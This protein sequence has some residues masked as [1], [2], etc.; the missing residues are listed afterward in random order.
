VKEVPPLLHKRSVWKCN[1][2]FWGFSSLISLNIIHLCCSR[3]PKGRVLSLSLRVRMS[4]S[5]VSD[6]QMSDIQMSDIQMSDIQ[7]SDIWMSDI[8]IS[9]LRMSD[10]RMSNIRVSNIRVSNIRMSDIRMSDIR[11]LG[12]T[13]IVLDILV[14][15]LWSLPLSYF[16][17]IFLHVL[18]QRKNSHSSS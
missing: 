12:Y 8:R 2:D 1:G 7:L 11:V 5:Q 9:D 18:P 4:D 13:Y 15:R 14:T 10:I 17:H 16:L 3:Y 6:I